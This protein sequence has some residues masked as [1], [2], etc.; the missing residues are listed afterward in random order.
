MLARVHPDDRARM[1]AEIER[2]QATE[3]PFEGEFRILTPDGTER[4]VL[5]KGRTVVEPGDCAA[6]RVGVVLDITERKQAEEKLRESEDRFRAL[7]NA[8]P[9]MI[10]MAGTDKLG[11][12]FNKGWLDFTGRTLEEQLGNGWAKGMHEEDS[13]VVLK[14]I[15]VPL[16]HGESLPWNTACG[17]TT[18][19]IAGYSITLCRELG[20]TVF[21]WLH[22]NCHRYYRP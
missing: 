7:A 19:N 16:T 14:F 1:I 18:V 2:A 17:D 20:L 4:W 9:V 21:P 10:W 13:N 6:R 11:T 5:A 22:R 15:R 12:F 3:L 8:A